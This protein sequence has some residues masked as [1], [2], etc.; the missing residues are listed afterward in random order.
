M[1]PAS[2]PRPPTPHVIPN[3]SDQ[4]SNSGRSR[5]PGLD[6]ADVTSPESYGPKSSNVP[7]QSDAQAKMILPLSL[8]RRG[9]KLDLPFGVR[10]EVGNHRAYQKRRIVIHGCAKADSFAQ[11]DVKAAANCQRQ[12]G[13][14]MGVSVMNASF[15]GE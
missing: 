3:A 14:R 9:S 5:T 10:R 2:R 6:R 11:P 1:S 7:H 13:I 12:P 15:R 8:V 4:Y